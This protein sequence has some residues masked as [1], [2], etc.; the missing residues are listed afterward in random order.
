[1]SDLFRR[2]YRPLTEGEK[3]LMDQIKEKAEEFTRLLI[4]VGTSREVSLAG[5]KI[6]EAVMWATKAVTR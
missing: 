2:G 3:V 6:E 1:M 5:T 4:K